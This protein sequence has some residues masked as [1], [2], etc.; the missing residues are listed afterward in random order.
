MYKLTI[1]IDTYIKRSSDNFRNFGNPFFEVVKKQN[2][3]FYNLYIA[4]IS[5]RVM[6]RSNDSEK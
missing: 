3:V 1:A 4:F 2:F 6:K 5:A